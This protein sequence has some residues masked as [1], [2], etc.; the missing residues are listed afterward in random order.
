MVKSDTP[1]HCVMNVVMECVNRWFRKSLC[2]EY[3]NR[4]CVLLLNEDQAKVRAR[5]G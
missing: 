5:H 4:L 3:R 1:I 2:N